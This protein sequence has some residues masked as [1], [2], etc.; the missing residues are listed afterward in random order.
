MIG[1]TFFENNKSLL[2]VQNLQITE[3]RI[4]LDS[5]RFSPSSSGANDGI[6]ELFKKRKYGG[7]IKINNENEKE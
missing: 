1:C 6:F 5:K 7:K 3:K 2:V 4:L